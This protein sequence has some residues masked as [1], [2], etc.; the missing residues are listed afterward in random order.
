MNFLPSSSLFLGLSS[1]ASVRRPHRE[2]WDTVEG[3][4]LDDVCGKLR[5]APSPGASA[6]RDTAET[7]PAGEAP[8][9]PG[10]RPAQAEAA[11][12]SQPAA[13][14]SLRDSLPNKPYPSVAK[15]QEEPGPQEKR[16]EEDPPNSPH[17][18]LPKEAESPP[19]RNSNS[20]SARLSPVV[21]NGGGSCDQFS[22]YETV[23]SFR[24]ASSGF[25]ASLPTAPYER[26][27]FQRQQQRR[28]MQQ[29]A[30]LM[31]LPTI[32]SNG[33]S[34]EMLAAVLEE[35][36]QKQEQLNQQVQ[37]QHE[38]RLQEATQRETESAEAQ[39]HS[40]TRSSV[41]AELK[42]PSL[43][44]AVRLQLLHEVM[45][46]TASTPNSSLGRSERK[47]WSMDDR[48]LESFIFSHHRTFLRRLG[49]W[50]VAV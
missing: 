5:R 40:P 26:L 43:S 29:Q 15:V 25:A 11:G 9:S 21:A 8:D 18:A 2:A 16:K 27:L 13:V 38:Q 1:T 12:G 44:P 42:G 35:K 41:I 50:A 22:R 7:S 30:T 23:A 10:G 32:S 34:S 33:G 49:R 20:N 36:H 46:S 45:W 6:A 37:Q 47:W 39:G 19:D 17:P 48:N 24:R 4:E 31:S 14:E 3:T 28:L